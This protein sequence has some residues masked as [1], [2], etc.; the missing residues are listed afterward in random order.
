MLDRIADAY[1]DEVEVVTE[2]VTV[3]LEPL[4]IVVLAVV[5]GFI[6][7][8]IILPILQVGNI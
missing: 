3:V 5:V 2:R 1:D 7:Y 6:V 8:S 4:M